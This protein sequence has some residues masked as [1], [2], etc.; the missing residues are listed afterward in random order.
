MSDT[1]PICGGV[2]PHATEVCALLLNERHR[3]E[4]E[5]LRRQ[6]AE[7][8]A[9]IDLM[10][11]AQVQS[12]ARAEK[13]EGER[14]KARAALPWTCLGCGKTQTVEVCACGDH[15]H[16]RFSAQVL[17]D[18][19]AAAEAI[20]AR[21]P[22]TADG[23]PVVPGMQVWGIHCGQFYRTNVSDKCLGVA[24]ELPNPWCESEADP[25]AL[26][27]TRAAA[28]AAKEPKRE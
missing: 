10:T 2:T 25:G 12:Y 20:V 21:L 17:L 18:R 1:C 4:A 26:Y 5:N 22:R 8:Q 3:K 9:T 24:L 15:A 6:L 28:E 27:S 19:L 11:E 16:D 7:A 23:V 14:D 13:A